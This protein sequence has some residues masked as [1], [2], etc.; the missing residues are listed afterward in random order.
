MP[1]QS[2]VRATESLLEVDH[3]V[4]C[5]AAPVSA[6]DL[7]ELGLIS[8]SQP[9]RRSQQGTASHLLFFENAYLELIWVED[10]IAAEIYAMKSGIDF[11][12]R[13]NW[14]QTQA[15]PFSMALRPKPDASLRP[16]L[17]N[18][19]QSWINFAAANWRNQ[20]EPLCFVIPEAV[21]LLSLL[22]AN[23]ARHQQLLSHPISIQRLTSVSMTI[24]SAT[25]LTDSIAL[26]D[27]EGV[28]SIEL[29][30]E[31][32]LDLTFDH[33][34]QKRTLDLGELGI[35]ALLNY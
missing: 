2:L 12:A 4:I 34:R 21:S 24:S 18:H 35:P 20:S 32:L 3:L 15:S 13:A 19:A 9:L 5:V 1:L 23:S 17:P 8:S 27:R 14:R 33:R 11:L 16:S 29:R 6:L 28:I 26:L 25:Q 22:D 31:P 30:S 10:E 7:A